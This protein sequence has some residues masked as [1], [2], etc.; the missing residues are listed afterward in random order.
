M[1]DE[2]ID[3][4]LNGFI[5]QFNGNEE[6]KPLIVDWSLKLKISPSDDTFE[7]CLLIEN[8]E[9]IAKAFFV[10]VTKK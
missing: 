10:N 3:H 6:V 9:M 8:Q 2:K 1:K 5:Q 7:R 4:L